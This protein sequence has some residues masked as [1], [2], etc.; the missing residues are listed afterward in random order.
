MFVYKLKT[1]LLVCQIKV[2]YYILWLNVEILGSK[3]YFI[4]KTTKKLVKICQNVW[5]PHSLV[6]N[7][8]FLK[9]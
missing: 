2:K 3:N 6:S 1:E 8:N 4:T 5:N 9:F 7:L